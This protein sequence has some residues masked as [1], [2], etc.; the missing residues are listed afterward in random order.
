MRLIDR[1]ILRELGGIFLFG[2]AIFTGLLLVITHLFFVARLAA[3]VGLPIRTSLALLGLKVPYFVVF[4]LPMAMLLATL[5]AFGRLSERNEITAMRTTGWSLGRITAPVLLAGVAVTGC[6]L[7]L[8]EYV[9]PRTE[10]RYAE[11]LAAA[12]RAPA[13]KVQRDVLFREP[14]DGV[15]SLFFARELDTHEGTMTRVVITQFLDGRP[16]RLI[17][18]ERARYGLDGWVLEDGTL[19]LLGA[20]PGVKTEFRQMRVALRR[21]PPQVAVVR[22]DPTEMTI[23]ELRE[24]IATLRAAGENLVR[25]AVSLHFKLALPASSIIFALLAVPLGLRP[26][27][28]GRST[29]LGLTILVVLAYYVMT[30]ITLQLGER[31]QIG[32]VLAAWLPNMSVGAAGLYLM[33]TAW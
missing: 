2:V 13:R 21:T 23:R 16:A 29:G 24:E 18:A 12:V 31:G 17:E 28:A 14:V 10:R 22:R 9:V 20:A 6:S 27:R 32:P 33:R 1:Y 15:E 8:N 4:A 11:V 19:Y 7:Y 25:Y 5:L 26:H 30:M 3:D